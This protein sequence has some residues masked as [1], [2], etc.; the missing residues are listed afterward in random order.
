MD[1]TPGAELAPMVRQT[2][3]AHWNRFAAVNDEFVPIHMDD[4]A[5]REAGFPSAIGMGNLIWSY[6]HRLLR[7]WLGGRGRIETINAR[8]WQPNLRDSTLVVRAKI[9]EVSEGDDATRVQLELLAEDAA[10][11]RLVTGQATVAVTRAAQA[12]D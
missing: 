4:A 8:Y 11:A 1:L 5:G 2:G 12:P 10:G 9:A 7:D 3:L 6:F